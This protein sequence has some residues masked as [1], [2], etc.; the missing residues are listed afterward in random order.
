MKCFI[1]NGYHPLGESCSGNDSRNN[2]LSNLRMPL[3]EPP[4]FELPKPRFN[5]ILPPYEPPKPTFDLFSKPEP[6]IPPP[7]P[8]YNINH[9]L[10]GWKP[11]FDNHINLGIGGNGQRL[12]INPGGFVRDSMDN[13]IGQMGPLNILLPP[14]LPT[15]PDYGPPQSTPEAWNPGYSPMSPFG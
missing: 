8:V 9:D 5:P 10:I 6:L 2:F 12:E 1:C 15:M 3:Y 14:S 13:L 11:E 4:S 7:S